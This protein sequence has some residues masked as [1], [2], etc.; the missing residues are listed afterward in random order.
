MRE[1]QSGHIKEA[2]PQQSGVTSN[3]TTSNMQ[4]EQ[5][6]ITSPTPHQDEDINMQLEAFTSKHDGSL[7]QLST[8]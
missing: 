7:L 2:N 8:S 4:K 6:C 5:E 1:L 3:N